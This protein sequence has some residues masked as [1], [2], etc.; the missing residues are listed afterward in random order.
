MIRISITRFS[1]MKM[2]YFP[3]KNKSFLGQT[4]INKVYF[5][6][7]CFIYWRELYTASVWWF[8]S[9]T[10]SDFNN[11]AKDATY[12]WEYEPQK[13]KIGQP[14]ISYLLPPL[15]IVQ[16]NADRHWDGVSFIR[17][18]VGEILLVIS[19]PSFQCSKKCLKNWFFLVHLCL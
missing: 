3:T 15:G 10:A 1:L 17:T 13:D 8:V 6:H 5:S 9:K 4:F 11:V 7:V 18:P 12:S 14:I 2:H 16:C 19:P